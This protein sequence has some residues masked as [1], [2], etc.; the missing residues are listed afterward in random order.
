M[1]T[2]KEFLTERKISINTDQEL[3]KALYDVEANAKGKGK[4]LAMQAAEYVEDNGLDQKAA[5]LITAMSSALGSRFSQA[6]LVDAIE[7][8]VEENM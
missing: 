7:D 1:K 6:P 3:I 2:F 5:K 4:T 8:Y